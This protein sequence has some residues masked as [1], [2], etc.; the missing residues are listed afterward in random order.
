M[1]ERLAT[2]VQRVPYDPDA[3]VVGELERMG[4]IDLHRFSDEFEGE[5][6]RSSRAQMRYLAA[7]LPDLDRGKLARAI[8]A[9][10]DNPNLLERDI[11][12]I[13]DGRS[14]ADPSRRTREVP[15]E[16]IQT[17][18]RMLMRG[19]TIEE[20]ARAARVSVN[21]VEAID[22]FLGLVQARKDHL[23]D[24]AVVAIREGWSVRQLARTSNISKSQA[25]RLMVQAREVLAEIG[26]VAR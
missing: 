18:G 5:T 15:I 1:I 8:A 21:T 4:Y 19:E 20:T 22:G 16:A 6:S 17:V 11:R 3:P 9:I 2:R 10:V 13:L 24:D 14:L 7:L 23:L 12:I 25:H 26:E